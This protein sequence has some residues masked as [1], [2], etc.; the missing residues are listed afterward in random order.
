M[1]DHADHHDAELLLRLY[2]IRR[3]ARL[4]QARDWYFRE[5]HVGTFEELMQQYPPGSPE[6]ASFR[7]VVS[8]W[9]MACSIVNQGLIKEEF[10]FENTNEFWVVWT[11]VKHLAPTM[12]E[13]R[14]NPFIWKNLDDLA[15]RYEKWMSKRAPDALEAFRQQVLSP[16]AKK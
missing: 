2:D 3:E 14:K 6:N 15:G 13:R 1:H 5:F 12:R 4:R 16:P 11:K 8:Y 10:F 9:D 7:M